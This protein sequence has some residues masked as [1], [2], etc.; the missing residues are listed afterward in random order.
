[1]TKSPERIT[2]HEK[3]AWVLDL[4]NID[5]CG[6][7]LHEGSMEVLHFNS[8]NDAERA[9]EGWVA[10][11]KVKRLSWGGY[12]STINNYS[13][14]SIS[15]KWVDDVDSA[16][17]HAELMRAADS[18]VKECES[19]MGLFPDQ[20]MSLDTALTAYEEAKEKINAL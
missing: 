4:Y 13:S 19:L 10:S 9:L 8:K 17:L 1:M 20:R 14:V 6:M 5:G 18:V 3:L 12:V 2:K 16:D 15:R 7:G 11:G